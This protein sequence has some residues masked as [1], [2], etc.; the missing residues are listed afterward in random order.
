MVGC[1]FAEVDFGA[2]KRLFLDGTATRFVGVN[3]NGSTVN[4]LTEGCEALVLVF[5][6]ALFLSCLTFANCWGF[7][8]TSLPTLRRC[9]RM[10]EVLLG[11]KPRASSVVFSAPASPKR[12]NAGHNVSSLLGRRAATGFPAHG[13]R[14]L[15]VIMDG[16]RRFGRSTSARAVPGEALT[17]LCDMIFRQRGSFRQREEMY[18]SLVHLLQHTALDGHRRGGEKLLEFIDY[19][20][21][22]NI[23]ML[24]V[25]AFSTENWNR[26]PMEINVLMA[27]FCFFFERIR[28]IAKERGVFIRFISP[29]FEKIT[30]CLQELMLNIERESRQHRPRRIVVNV[31]VSYSGQEEMLNACN[32]LLQRPDKIFPISS[33]DLMSC[34]LRSVTQ[35]SYEAEDACVLADGGG[36]EPQLLLRTSGEQRLSNFLLYECAYTEFVFVKKTWPEITREDF[37]RLLH[38]FCQRHRRRGR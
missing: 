27:L 9:L 20:I 26:S 3:K 10:C 14:H 21:E 4:A 15:A 37:V 19:C 29:V 7:G 12:H 5:S 23:Q 32:Y 36:A 31:C 30:P 34:M 2:Q 22:F 11:L 24:T 17:R 35:H 38:D 8:G 28:E 1:V 25:Y 13:V 18:S 33:Q 6:V 16:N